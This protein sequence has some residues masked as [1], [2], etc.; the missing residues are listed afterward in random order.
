MKHALPLLSLLFLLPLDASPVV[1]EGEAGIGKGKHI[2]FIASDHEYRS[3]ETCPALA[4]ILAKR[5]GFKCTVCFGVDEDGYIKAGESNIPGLEALQTADLMVIFT[6]FQNLPGEQMDHIIAYLDRGGPVVGLRTSSHAFKIP[7]DSPYAKY[8]FQSKTEGYEKGFGHQVLGNTWVG[9]YGKNHVQGTRIQLV[10]EQKDHPILKGVDDNAFC[11]AGG[12]VG[13]PGPDFTVLTMTQPLLTMEKDGQPDPSKPPVASTWTRHY[14]SKSGKKPRVF[15]STQGAS[16][17]I[18]DADYRR[19]LINGI[20]WAAGMESKIAPGLNIDF[21]G[22]YT[23]NTFSNAGHAQKVKPSDLAGWDAPIMPQGAEHKPAKRQPKPRKKPEPKKP[24]AKQPDRKVEDAKNTKL[25]KP[26]PEQDPEL[27]DYYINLK[28]SP[29]PEAAEP[30]TTALPLDIARG[31]RIALIGNLLLD[32]ERRNGHL[33]ALLHQRFPAHQ[34]TVR[35]LSW[36]A[37]EVD[38]QPRPDNFGDLDQHLLYFKTDLVIAAFGYNES[39]AGKAGLPS[40]RQR[41]DKFLAHLKSRAYNGKS[42]PRVVLLSPAANENIPE[43]PAADLNNANIA[44][45]RDALKEAAAKHRLGFADVLP[46]TTSAFADPATR[47]TVDG[48]ALNEA[49]HLAFSRAAYRGLFNDTPP[50]VDDSLRA[51]VKDKASQFFP[52]YRPLNTFYYTGGRNKSYGYLDFLPAMRNYDLMTANRDRAIWSSAGG[53]PTAPDDS[54][55]P[56]LDEVVESRGANEWLSP[57]KERAAFNVDPR[58]EVNCFA[59]EEEFPEIACPIQMRWDARGRLWVSC[60]TTYPHLY[61]GNEP[62]DKIVILE[63]TDHDGKADKC[64]TFADDLHIPLSFVLDGQ[65]GVYVSEEPHLSHLRDTDGDG[66]ADTREIVFT[67]FGCEDSHHALHDFTWTPGGDLLFRESIFHNSQVESV[68]GPIRA[69]NSSWFLYH[70]GTR[71]LT[72]FGAY[73]NTNPWGVTFDK[74]GNH[75]ASHPV[76]ASTFHATN[77]AYPQQHP[78]ADGMQA[79][80]GVCGHDFV[81]FPSWPEEMQGGFLKVRY[82]PTNRVEIHQWIEKEDCFEEKYV[83]DLIFST[84]LS[85]I[86][87]DARFG[88]RGAFY[89]CDWYNPVKGHAQY[90][91]RDPRRDRKSGR[92]WRVVPKGAELQ[93]PPKIADAS[94]GELLEHLKSPHY[95]VRYWAKR[96]L[97]ARDRDQVARRLKAWIGKTGNELHLLE[98]LWLSMGIDRPNGALL[99]RLSNSGDHLVAAAA[100][101]PL[102]FWH[103]DLGTAQTKALLEKAANHPSQHVR[104]EAVLAAS[105]VGGGKALE[106]VL[107]VLDQPMGTHL[108]YAAATAFGSENLSPHWAGSRHEERIG[109]FLATR[110]KS[111]KLKPVTRSATDADFDSRRGLQEV[112]IGCVP[113]R[114]LFTVTS[115]TVKRGQPVKLTLSNP[116][117]T[118][119]NLVILEKGASLEEIGMAA[120]EMAKSP[121]GLKKH[122]V[123]NDKR[124]LHH[125]RLLD[126]NTAETLRFIAPKKPGAYPF[127]CTFPGHWILMKGE[128]IVK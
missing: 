70:P 54:N 56:P 121:E 71:K 62:N 97:R 38:L 27:A 92:I 109:A 106:A 127:V 128:M 86:P 124:I 82:K 96:E 8:D 59:S 112:A 39:F 105:Y 110:S 94:I 51:L 100:M 31:T 14:S 37:D 83:S 88:P 19:L 5:H 24:A 52:R 36:P 4:R 123:P 1:Y 91:L 61:P 20:L 48:N 9:H 63:D 33:E 16:E 64:S 18:L 108:A 79:Y 60:S 72:A 122:F 102:R 49:G 57:A 75:V 35:N 119:H 69:K 17:D 89:I 30:L 11:H 103:N 95:R 111:A 125:T 29:R 53:T 6:R 21:V 41:L 85:F 43:V 15:H 23:P 65:G 28:T 12:Y 104:R 117:A 101:G 87:V 90:S 25:D 13:E 76:F 7:S 45:Y 73:P 120:N 32:G 99:E 116:D 81:D 66:R 55:L 115:F 40:F 118:Q 50:E 80:S 26:R 42:A 74:Y 22:P 44:L 93:E 47:L 2:V 126:P 107:P 58:F 78:R 46:A 77:P 84:N 98:G 67:G 113:E 10:P 34:L 3:E 114:L 68:Y